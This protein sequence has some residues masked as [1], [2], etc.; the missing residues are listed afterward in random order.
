MDREVQWATVHG[1]AEL[2]TTEHI[3]MHARKEKMCIFLFS[4]KMEVVL[5]VP[6]GTKRSLIV[7]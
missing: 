4:P 5:V 7:L 3:C 2:D 1:A 6:K